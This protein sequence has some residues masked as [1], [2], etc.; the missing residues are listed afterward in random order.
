MISTDFE[1]Q[2][3]QEQLDHLEKWLARLRQNP[4]PGKDGL[5]K[6]GIRKL[7]ARFHEEL[8]AYEGTLDS[9]PAVTPELEE[10]AS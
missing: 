9:Q 3:S 5:V 1:Y 2:R 4:D 6:A 10:V 7:I 8:A